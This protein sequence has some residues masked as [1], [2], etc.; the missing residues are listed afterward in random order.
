MKIFNNILATTALAAAMLAT[1]CTDMDQ[2]PQ[3][4][5]S[6]E[7]YFNTATELELY[8]NQFYSLMP[9]VG[10]D[11]NWYLEQGEHIVTPV[12]NRAI[13]G[14]RTM[15][16]DADEV[17]WN[18]NTLRKINYY[19]QNSGRC[20]DERTRKRYDG[21][22]YFF[23]AYFYY[24]MLTKFGEVPWY[25]EPIASDRD[26][27]LKKPRD[28]RET[29]IGHIIEDLDKAYEY[30]DMDCQPL[31]G[32]GAEIACVP[33][34]RHFPKISRRRRVQPHVAALERIA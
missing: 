18:W 20:S 34:R 32:T 12:M 11:F 4:K 21:V 15:P 16:T 5:L 1:S 27:L 10:S 31:D 19:L 14:Q 25:D 28:S 26:D 29:I 3:D 13:L 23:R 7:V 33:L 24:N 22:A 6:P 8:T 30:L 2:F 17:A 9:S